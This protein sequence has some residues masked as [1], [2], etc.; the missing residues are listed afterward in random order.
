MLF[1]YITLVW[2]CDRFSILNTVER[3]GAVQSK[4]FAES[5][6]GCDI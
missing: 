4:R 2:D 6:T 1:M 5:K 3:L